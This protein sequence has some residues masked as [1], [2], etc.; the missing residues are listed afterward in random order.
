MDFEDDD[1]DPEDGFLDPYPYDLRDPEFGFDE[2]RYLFEYG[3][4]NRIHYG[5]NYPVG[6]SYQNVFTKTEMLQ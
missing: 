1:L 2:E 6:S 4:P 5:S 3:P